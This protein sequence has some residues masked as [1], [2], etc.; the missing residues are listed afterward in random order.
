MAKRKSKKIQAAS[1]F[2]KE[3][4]QDILQTNDDGNLEVV[5]GMGR[6]SLTYANG[7]LSGGHFKV[8]SFCKANGITIE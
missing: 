8:Q 1:I 3:V 2:T 7:I 5:Y 6:D 4:L